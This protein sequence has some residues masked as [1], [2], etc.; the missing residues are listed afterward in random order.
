MEMMEESNKR[1]E[2]MS[3]QRE[4]RIEQLM[5]QILIIEEMMNA[6]EMS[7]RNNSQNMP[8]DQPI[9]NVHDFPIGPTQVFLPDEDDYTI[10]IHTLPEQPKA[11]LE[12]ESLIIETTN[13][14]DQEEFEEDYLEDDNTH[15]MNQSIFNLR[16]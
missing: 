14:I 7:E 9:N 8:L 11:N 1:M 6:R 13:V 16:N 3:K 10:Q 2:E 5:S 15:S 4:E 12:R